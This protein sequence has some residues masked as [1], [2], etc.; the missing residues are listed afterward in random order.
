MHICIYIYAYMYIYICIYVYIYIPITLHSKLNSERVRAKAIVYTYIPINLRGK[1]NSERVRAKPI[2]YMYSPVTLH[3][4]LSSERV[5]AKAIVYTYTSPSLYTANWT[6]SEFV[7]KPLYSM[8]LPSLCRLYNYDTIQWLYHHH[9]IHHT[10]IV[11][12]VLTLTLHTKMCSELT[13]D[14]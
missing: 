12:H 8:F 13:H 7:P 14:M 9:T 3:C 2:V 1:L 5:G 10:I 6:A 11:F 4:K